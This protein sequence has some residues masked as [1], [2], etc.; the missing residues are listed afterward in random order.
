M[1]VDRPGEASKLFEEL[2][3]AGDLD[4]LM[5]LHEDAAVFTN[6]QGVHTGS[7]AIREVLRGSSSRGKQRVLRRLLDRLGL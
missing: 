5:D 2:F 1:G 3:A 7:E 4:G 6:A